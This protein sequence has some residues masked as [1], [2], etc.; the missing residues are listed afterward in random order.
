MGHG[1]AVFVDKQAGSVFGVIFFAHLW[2]AH[3]YLGRD[4]E[5]PACNLRDDA[6]ALRLEG[7]PSSR[8]S[9]PAPGPTATQV[10]TAVHIHDAHLHNLRHIDVTIPHG[11]LVAFTGISGSGKSSLAFGT[12]H[13]EGQR[14]YLESVAPFARR[15]ISQA[16]DPQVGSVEGLSPTVALQQQTTAPGARSTVG[17]ISSTSNIVRL[18]YS[19][20]GDYSRLAD[21]DASEPITR[22]NSDSF[23]PNTAEGMCPECRGT[24]TKF[25]A[26]EASMVHE[27]ELSIRDGAITAWPGAW[28][29]KNF[30]DILEALGYDIDRPWREL[31][32]ADREW[33]L[34]TRE[35]P[36]VEIVPHRGA[37]QIQR[38]YQ[39]TWRSVAEYLYK[40]LRETES[41]SLRRRT[42]SFLESHTCSN[43]EGAGLQPVALQ[44][45][46]LGV[47][48]NEL[49]SWSLESLHAAL[50]RRQEE[51]GAGE[52]GPSRTAQDDAEALLLTQ[53]IPPLAAA[54]ELGLGHLSLDRA[55]PTLS[56]GEL[57]RLRLASQLHSSLFGVTYI[58]DEPTAGLHPQERAAVLTVIRRLLAAGNNVFVVEH[59]MDFVAAADYLIDIGPYA[60]DG[61]GT[62]VYAGPPQELV[63]ATRAGASTAE[64]AAEPDSGPTAAP[65]AR[66]LAHRELTLADAPRTATGHLELRGIN[67]RNLR[68]LDLEVGLGQFTA[69]AGVSGSG[70]STLVTDVVAKRATEHPDLSRVVMITQKPIGRTPRSTLATYTGIFDRIR[71]IFAAQARR[72]GRD[73]KKWNASR[74]SYN[75]KKGQ[76]PECS[77]A[78]HIE[79]ELVFLPGTYTVCPRCQGGRFN[80]EALSVSWHDRTVADILRLRVAEAMEFFRGLIAP[81]AKDAKDANAADTAA[82]EDAASEDSA[83]NPNHP[84]E[85]QIKQVIRALEV[86]DELGLGYLRLG[87]GAPE[88]SGGEAQRIKLATELQRVHKKSS[89]YVL[90]EPTMGLHPH[91]SAK[92]LDKLEALVDDGATV[93]IVEHNLEALARVDRVVE[94]GPGAG[95]AGG[96]ILAEV[97]PAQLA[98]KDTATGRALAQRLR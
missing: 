74:F 32:D 11:K 70:K 93:V 59:D 71:S 49:N 22:L 62:V 92:L 80:D 17:T 14:S 44:V 25:V 43:C 81:D 36:V 58:L 87:Q 95:T 56:A 79:V 20:C 9:A 13:G 57:Q 65:T 39:G 27:P 96:R 26:T 40:T 48:I 51:L 24:G 53:I 98:E 6:A 84:D 47:A 42:E 5:Q 85:S 89:L 63:D 55:A 75:T 67:H 31:A 54:L 90:D 88:L 12:I 50:C 30:R 61:G 18:L 7:M 10:P 64:P 77:G 60:G 97:S 46:Y 72:D 2:P 8:E 19:R 1:P 4:L 29:G 23:S 34:F 37:D 16:T 45:R 66:A 3:I 91:D 82:S 68:Q 76:C 28:A 83:P 69:V 78:G 21:G 38:T 41:D 86:L 33:I 94:L 15:L 73:A 52:S 35:R